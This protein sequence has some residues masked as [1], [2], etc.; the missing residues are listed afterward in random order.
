MFLCIE[1]SP[2]YRQVL[3]SVSKPVER[4]MNLQ[5]TGAITIDLDHHREGTKRISLVAQ[6]LHFPTAAT[7][8]NAP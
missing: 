3:Y 8:S 4:K 2:V 7:F 6:M 5:G 1:R